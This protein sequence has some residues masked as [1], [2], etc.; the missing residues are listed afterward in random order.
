GVLLPAQPEGVR[1]DV[2]EHA[3]VGAL[4]ADRV[5]PLGDLGGARALEQH[6]VGEALDLLR[7]DPGHR[8]HLLHGRSGA[9]AGLDLSWAQL[10]L[11]LYRDLSETGEVTPR[12][13]TQLLVGRDRVALAPVRVLEHDGELPVLLEDPDDPQRPHRSASPLS[14]PVRVTVVARS[15]PTTEARRTRQAGSAAMLCPT[16]VRG[17]AP[18]CAQRSM[19]ITGAELGAGRDAG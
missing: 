11:H 4:G 15:R 12:G 8:G 3:G 10:A 14:L 17:C 16:G 9:D 7:R 5:R 13:R 19:S 2:A 6:R 1:D 18:P